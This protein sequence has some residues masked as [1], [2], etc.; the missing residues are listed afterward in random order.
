MRPPS[1]APDLWDTLS[2][3]RVIIDRLPVALLPLA[4]IKNDA[5]RRSV[6]GLIASQGI[7]VKVL[8][9]KD[10][11]RCFVPEIQIHSATRCRGKPRKRRVRAN[12][13]H[14]HAR[15]GCTKKYV[16][17]RDER[18][19]SERAPRSIQNRMHDFPIVRS[20]LLRSQVMTAH[21]QRSTEPPVHVFRY[22]EVPTGQIFNTIANRVH[23]RRRFVV[24][25][26]V[27]LLP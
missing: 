19:F 2:S 11:N 6:I 3:G 18:G 1:P 23:A 12:G 20:Q 24:F 9:L 4:Y 21:I 25:A 7:R 27:C 14:L 15:T 17:E 10:T 22:G 13:C 26:H 5:G 8:P 16:T